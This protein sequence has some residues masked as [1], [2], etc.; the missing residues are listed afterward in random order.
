LTDRL[1]AFF[2]N[3]NLRWLG[4]YSYAM[5]V[6]QLPLIVLVAPLVSVRELERFT[7][8]PNVAGLLY[9][10]TMLGL[11]CSLAWGSFHLFEKHFL[12]LKPH[13]TPP[14]ENAAETSTLSSPVPKW[15]VI[16]R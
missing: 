4:K 5:Y 7:G 13:A 9:M 2:R 6:F 3:S 10:M 1:A 8:D 14:L 15:S 16:Q 12:K 11:T